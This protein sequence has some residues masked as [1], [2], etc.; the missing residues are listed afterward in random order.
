MGVFHLP[1]VE[2]L[3]LL[4][5]VVEDL[6]EDFGVGGVAECAGSGQN[7]LGGVVLACEVGEILLI[8]AVATSLQIVV[9]MRLPAVL[10]FLH[11][12]TA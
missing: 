12:A 11:H 6:G 2:I 10:K 1:A 3:G 7:P 9:M 4:V 8:L 5:I